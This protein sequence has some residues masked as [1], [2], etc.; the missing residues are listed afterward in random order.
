MKIICAV[1]RIPVQY[2]AWW[3]DYKTGERV[4]QVRCHGAKEEMRMKPESMSIA[5]LKALENADGVAFD[6]PALELK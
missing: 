2:T 3:D 1:C 6:K 4:I 5:T